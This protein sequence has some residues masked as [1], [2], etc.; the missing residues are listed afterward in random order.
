MPDEFIQLNRDFLPISNM[1]KAESALDIE[2]QISF[3]FSS[4]VHWEDLLKEPRVVILA[5]AGAGK[6]YEIRETTKS[7][8]GEGKQAFFL[9]LE[10]LRDEFEFAF[11]GGTMGEFSEFT[12]WM[13][14]TE[15]AWFFL[16]SVDEAKLRD[17]GDF[18]KV[19]LRLKMWLKDRIHQTNIVITSRITWEPYTEFSLVKRLL[20]Y[21][22]K[23]SAEPSETEKNP[24]LNLSQPDSA[25]VKVPDNTSDKE[26][27]PKVYSLSP[28]GNEQ[29][30]I[31]A[32][33]KGISDTNSFLG[34]IHRKGVRFIFDLCS[35]DLSPNRSTL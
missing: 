15:K 5:E 26:Q 10:Y 20:P 23:Q 19:L 34:A 3:G 29:I 16:D 27:D 17:P 21:P 7:L 18:E 35:L 14:T 6:T 24:D 25:N 30:K 9:R 33:A 12:S 22:K 8:R 4:K 2:T 1:D 31:F 11:E 13:Q 28:L 32:E